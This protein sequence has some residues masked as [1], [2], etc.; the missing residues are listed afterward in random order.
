MKVQVNIKTLTNETV[1]L[2][3][4]VSP[5]DTA[6]DLKECI[7]LAEPNPF[8]EQVLSCQGKAL[9]DGKT[10]SDCGVQ[11]GSILDFEAKASEDALA[12]QFDQLLSSRGCIAIEELGLLYSLK[13]GVTA[14]LVLQSLG[15]QI[16]LPTFLEKFG[17]C[18]VVNDGKVKSATKAAVAT[19]ESLLA[20]PL[21]QIPEDAA[22]QKLV[23]AVAVS[24]E[25][26]YAT[27]SGEALDLCVNTA[28]T[29]RIVK[30]RAAAAALVPFPDR[31][32]SFQGKALHDEKTLADCGVVDSS[33][34]NFVV[35][36]TEIALITQLMVILL[37]RGQSSR[38]E[39]DNLYCCRHGVSA[40]QALNMLGWGEKL[41]EF[42]QRQPFFAV[43]NGCVSLARDAPP[44]PRLSRFEE[45][46]HTYLQLSAKLC[47]DALM[48]KL[49]VELDGLV[50]VISNEAFLNISRTV[51]GGGLAKG[52]AIPGDVGAE[53]VLF[54]PGLALTDRDRWLP[55]LVGS[56]AGVL[57]ER[58][59]GH[60]VA[61]VRA[62]PSEGAVRVLTE[63]GLGEVR[64]LLSPEFGAYSEALQAMRSQKP[65][66]V[67]SGGEA[68]FVAQKVRFMDR[69]PAA[70]KATVRLLKYWR[71]QQQWSSAATRPSDELL[72]LVAAHL[73][74]RQPPTDL[75]CAVTDALA[76]LGSFGE[77]SV[78][79]PQALRTYRE[80]DVCKAL[81][82]Q[83]PLILDP[84]NP[85]ANLADASAF[86]PR[87]LV[88]HARRGFCL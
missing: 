44:S 70:V 50:D 29:V 3:I 20:K 19:S 7:A 65:A 36:C 42:L 72:E 28:D 2:A 57:T 45:E 68:A 15:K 16:L 37:A 60:G 64:L 9:K 32:L 77:L 63:G 87:E 12:Q 71:Q 61:A 39:L 76:A 43:Q 53:V 35:R 38:V 8:P 31:E 58:L 88:E 49:D 34:L 23:V 74:V 5:N 46:N 47:D 27:R 52:T 13:Y 81:L 85:L 24:L 75:R 6:S 22:V 14:G 51:K 4:A 1:T 56:L 54:V 48:A 67:L 41:L 18:F 79:W 59:V 30:D 17:K 55:G 62:E 69:Q 40:T 21:E 66:M 84:T 78:T 25:L 82:K 80:G 83:R 26:P 33:C 86:E 73:A 10:L 11:D